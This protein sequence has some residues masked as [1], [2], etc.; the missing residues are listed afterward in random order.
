LRF[1]IQCFYHSPS[2]C[3]GCRCVCK[4]GVYRLISTP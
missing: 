3:F 2:M 1:L 4:K